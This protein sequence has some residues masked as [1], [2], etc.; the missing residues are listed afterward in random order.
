M[1][2]SSPQPKNKWAKFATVAKSENELQLSQGVIVLK[3]VK[4]DY[5][6]KS[7]YYIL[8]F[9]ILQCMCL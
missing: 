7:L 1:I 6:P 5:M 4:I 8:N 2:T 3:W 9:H